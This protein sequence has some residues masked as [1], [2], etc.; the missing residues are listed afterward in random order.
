MFWLEKL[1]THGF[2]VR[3][4]RLLGFMALGVGVMDLWLKIHGLRV[5]GSEASHAPDA[6]G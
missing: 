5:E 1:G 4:L 3:G 6:I 2:T